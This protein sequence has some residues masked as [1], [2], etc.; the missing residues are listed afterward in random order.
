[1][2]WRGKYRDSSESAGGPRKKETPKVSGNGPCSL[3][4]HSN[5][6]AQ[7]PSHMCVWWWIRWVNENCAVWGAVGGV[8]FSK[9]NIRSSVGLF[10]TS[11]LYSLITF[12][13]QC[14]NSNYY[15]KTEN[16]LRSCFVCFVHFTWVGGFWNGVCGC[17]FFYLN[18]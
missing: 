13:V 17:R 18:L 6:P 14:Y 2:G 8:S 10:I 15:L 11:M 9:G 12:W 5:P 4:I 3:N 7:P 1:M 16:V